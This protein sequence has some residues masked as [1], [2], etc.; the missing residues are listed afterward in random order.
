MLLQAKELEAFGAVVFC[1]GGLMFYTMLFQFKLVPQWLS[2]WGLLALIMTLGGWPLRDVRP[3]RPSVEYQRC[4]T[5]SDIFPRN[6]SGRLDDR[7]K[8]VLYS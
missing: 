6:G 5:D 4:F 1:L 2:G 7:E 3:F 8:K